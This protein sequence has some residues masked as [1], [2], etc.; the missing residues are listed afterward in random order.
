M[1]I[2]AP[3]LVI[4]GL[5]NWIYRLGG[6][7]LVLL[8]IVDN[9]VV[10]IPGGMDIFV[11]LLAAHRRG[12]WLYY[13]FM[14][15]AGAV[16]GG[17]LTY[18][19]AQKGGE[20]TL[21]KKIG[22]DRAQKVYGKFKNRGFTTIA[23]SAVM[24]PPLMLPMNELLMMT[25]LCPA[26]MESA[27]TKRIAAR[28]DDVPRPLPLRMFLRMVKLSCRPEPSKRIPLPLFEMMFCSIIPP[29]V[30]APR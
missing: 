29:F 10:P 13:G 4:F 21:E 8:G 12:W 1:R 2:F 23:V 25:F 26:A 20:E 24:P 5:W 19:L 6:P 16:L 7:G 18:R 9:S 28:L 14:A 15:A 30:F 17:Y 11:I 27:L 22:K 3:I